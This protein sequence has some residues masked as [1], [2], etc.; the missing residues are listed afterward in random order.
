MPDPLVRIASV[1]EHATDEHALAYLAHVEA[2]IAYE[3]SF[4]AAY[5]EC[6]E[7]S[8]AAKERYANSRA[9]PERAAMKRAKAD[10]VKWSRKAK[11]ALAELSAMQTHSRLVGGQT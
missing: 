1:A 2:E 7:S 6:E 8:H 3:E 10:E 5:E 11:A 9:A 4:N